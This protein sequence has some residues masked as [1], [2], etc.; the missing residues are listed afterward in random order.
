M[1]QAGRPGCQFPGALVLLGTGPVHYGKMG[2][3]D[4]WPFLVFEVCCEFRE[5]GK[6]PGFPLAGTILDLEVQGCVWFPR[7]CPGSRQL[8]QGFQAPTHYP[9]IQLRPMV[10]SSFSSGYHSPPHDL[11]QGCV[12]NFSRVQ[13]PVPQDDPGLWEGPHERHQRG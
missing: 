6:L 2:G 9:K 10:A 11:N 8:R 13:V 5:L 12:L 4:L 1:L 7:D 3:L